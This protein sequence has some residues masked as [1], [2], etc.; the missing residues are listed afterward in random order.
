MTL[1]PDHEAPPVVQA[2]KGM[3]AIVCGLHYKNTKR[4]TEHAKRAQ[5]M[6]AH[7]LQVCPPDFNLPSL[8]YTLD[9]FSDHSHA[10]DI[11][12]L[13]YYTHWLNG[14]RIEVDTILRVA[15]IE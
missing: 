7:T 10:I 12:I 15:D 8:D 4:T 11:G 14:G 2:A 1:P 6:G 5:D 13:V 3:A 9:Y